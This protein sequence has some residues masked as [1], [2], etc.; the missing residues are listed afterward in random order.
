M[1]HT[2][3]YKNGQKM[4][5][6]RTYQSDS[7]YRGVHIITQGQA[8]RIYIRDLL[9]HQVLVERRAVVDGFE[10]QDD[11]SITHPVRAT[12]RSLKSGNKETIRAKFLVGADGATSS[13]R[14]QLNIPFDG[15]NTDIYWAIMDCVFDTDYPYLT[16]FRYV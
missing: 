4:F 13:I 11:P 15:T 12:V 14:K 10:V 8:E 9:R 2:V 3:I 6:K 7:R 5:Y 1:D 16:T